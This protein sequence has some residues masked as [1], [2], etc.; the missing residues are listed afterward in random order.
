MHPDNLFG[1]NIIEKGTTNGVQTDFDG[2][3]SLNV[4]S[5]KATLVVTYIGF[6]TK[7]V[8]LNGQANVV[9]KLRKI[10]QR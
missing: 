5:D 2:N 4:K 6:K 7:E 9:I 8:L 3:F 10:Q 1:V